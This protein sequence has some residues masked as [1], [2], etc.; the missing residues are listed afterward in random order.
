MA[1]RIDEFQSSLNI[2]GGVSRLEYFDCTIFGPQQ[3]QNFLN[4]RDLKFRIEAVDTPGRSI[5]TTEYFLYGPPQ[6]VGVGVAYGEISLTVILSS[7]L[8]ERKYFETWQDLII[9]NHRNGNQ[10]LVS[11]TNSFDIGYYDAYARDTSLTI[12]NY[13]ET[14]TPT[15]S[16]KLIEVFPSLISSVNYNWEAQGIAKLPVTMK[17]RYYETEN[18]GLPNINIPSFFNRFSF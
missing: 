15:H 3:L 6:Q 11:S 5:N 12:Q 7:D 13:S 1:F 4:L 17:Y 18:F 2:S 8:R 9:G 10:S 14:G 16:V